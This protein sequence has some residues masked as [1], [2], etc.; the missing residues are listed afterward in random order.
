MNQDEIFQ[1]GANPTVGASIP[2]RDLLSLTE[3]AWL[4]GA[5]PQVIGE[6]LEYELIEPCAR[7]P[8]PCFA[9]DILP[10][11]CKTVRLHRHL[12][13]SFCSM[14]LVLELL[15]RIEELERRLEELKRQQ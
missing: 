10:Q 1:A 13:I 2:S 15:G 8:A 3:L 12:G 11:V 14:G 6:L 7:N 5:T 4:T 9:V